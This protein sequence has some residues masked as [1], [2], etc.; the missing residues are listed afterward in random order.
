MKSVKVLIV[1]DSELD[2]YILRR[3][4]KV[5]GVDK[6]EEKD[7]GST[8]LDY[9]RDYERNIRL[10]PDKY[11]PI[12]IFLDINMPKVNG[13]D[14]LKEF[15]ILRTQL[16][17]LSCVVVMYSSSERREDKERAL[18]YEFVQRYLVKGELNEEVLD[19]TIQA[20]G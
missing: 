12:V 13:F 5:L 15:A 16:A 14:F 19:E 2:R 1:D 7:D 10:H 9:L 6:V 4:L 17:I 20:L 3:Q 11:P 18:K 8:A